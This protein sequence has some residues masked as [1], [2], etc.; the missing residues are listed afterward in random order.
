M[1][2][3]PTYRADWLREDLLA[4]LNQV[5]N[6]RVMIARGDL[7]MAETL[8]NIAC[9]Q[10]LAQVLASPAIPELADSL[11]TTNAKELAA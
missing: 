7:R 8:L 4:V 6:A 11:A 5:Q 9:A 2:L 1:A 3:S 10:K